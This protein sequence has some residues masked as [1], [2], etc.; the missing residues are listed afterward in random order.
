MYDWKTSFSNFTLS[1]KVKLSCFTLL[2][3]VKLKVNLTLPVK[4]S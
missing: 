2:N 4:E 3:K 1:G